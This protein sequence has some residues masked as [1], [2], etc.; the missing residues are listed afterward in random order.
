MTY[1]S[2]P[3]APVTFVIF[4]VIDPFT[5]VNFQFIVF[6]YFHRWSLDCL[7]FSWGFVVAFI[8]K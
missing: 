1:F 4:Y 3:K 6:I 5:S 7:T 8:I 2:F